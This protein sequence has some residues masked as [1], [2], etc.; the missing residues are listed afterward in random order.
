MS[1]V[2]KSLDHPKFP[3]NYKNKKAEAIIGLVLISSTVSTVT[4]TFRLKAEAGNK[5]TNFW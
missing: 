3:Y 4:G 2:L 5:I 1:C